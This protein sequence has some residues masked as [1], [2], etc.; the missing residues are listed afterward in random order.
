[1][2]LFKEL[3]KL[4]MFFSYFMV[5]GS[6]TSDVSHINMK[7]NRLSRLTSGL[8]RDVDDIWIA[9]S[10]IA[11]KNQ[12]LSYNATQQEELN[13]KDV[14]QLVNGTVSE[15]KELKSEVDQLILYTK[16][17]FKREKTFNR[18]KLTQITQEQNKFQ[19]NVSRKISDFTESQRQLLNE[20]FE[21]YMHQAYIGNNRC[22]ILIQN[23]TNDFTRRLE[24]SNIERLST[25]LEDN[26]AEIES[27]HAK[28]TSM[29]EKLQ[30]IEQKA[31]TC[32]REAWSNRAKIAHLNNTFTNEMLYQLQLLDCPEGWYTFEE[33]CYYFSTVMKSFDD[34]NSFCISMHSRMVQTETYDEIRFVA[35]TCS[36]HRMWVGASDRVTEGT[37]IWISSLQPIIANHWNKGEPNNNNGKEDC[38]ELYCSSNSPNRKFNDNNCSKKYHFGC[39]RE[40]PKGTIMK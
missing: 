9:L 6:K 7:L 35:D 27:Y 12:K 29:E 20:E 33:H 13:S 22:E 30:S 11:V 36:A 25:K 14:I 28:L 18:R 26:T 19:A 38:L 23:T 34:A 16:K 31:D 4:T 8:Q 15:V 32:E 3:C 39:E 24:E 2:A 40:Q 10:Q 21:K 5:Y 1:M 17:G 37:F